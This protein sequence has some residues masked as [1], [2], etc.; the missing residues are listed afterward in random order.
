MSDTMFHPPAALQGRIAPTTRETPRGTVHDPTAQ[1]MGGVAGHAGLFTTTA[2]LARF[3]RMLLGRGSLESV[4]LLRP[5][6]VQLMTTAQ[7]PT[8]LTD[9]RGL[10]WDIDSRYSGPRGTVFPIGSYGHTG[11]TGGS[12][13]IDPASDTFVIFLSNRNHPTEAGNLIELRK[14]IGNL[15]AEAAG[16]SGKEVKV[17]SERR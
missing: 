8:A 14:V 13:W 10:G 4:H 16:M 2:D 15:A 17:G 11:W 9:R 5:E 12:L 3:A 1:L 6:T 7:S